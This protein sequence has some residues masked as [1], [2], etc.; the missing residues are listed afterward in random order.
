M[1]AHPVFRRFCLELDAPLAGSSAN[2][3]AG[4]PPRRFADIDTDLLVGADLV[5]DAGECGPGIPS[6][7]IDLSGAEPR[8]L[9]EGAVSRARVEQALGLTLRRP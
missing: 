8:L 3:H 7:V 4:Q 2:L 5:L 9:R 1:V 6:T